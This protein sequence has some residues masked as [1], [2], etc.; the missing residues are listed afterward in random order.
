MIKQRS[1][2]ISIKYRGKRYKLDLHVHKNLRGVRKA[3]GRAIAGYLPSRGRYVGA[4]HLSETRL[5][6]GNI[7]HEIIHVSL[8]IQGKHRKSRR[9]FK[10]YRMLANTREEELYVKLVERIQRKVV[11]AIGRRF[12]I[13][14]P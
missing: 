9:L 3:V 12:E 5:T 10:N 11:R 8:A 7:T 13:Q 2:Q 6:L 14:L 4:I 1:K